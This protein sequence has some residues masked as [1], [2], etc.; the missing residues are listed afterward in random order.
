MLDFAE[1]A[2]YGEGLVTDVKPVAESSTKILPINSLPFFHG[3]LSRKDCEALLIENGDFLIRESQSKRGQYVI[4][5]LHLGKYQHLL[6][7]SQD[8]KVCIHN[9]TVISRNLSQLELLRFDG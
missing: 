6:F 4:S 9:H 8:G 3:L 5:G 7:L 1:G 2:I